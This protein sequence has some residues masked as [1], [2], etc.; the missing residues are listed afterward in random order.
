MKAAALTPLAGLLMGNQSCQQSAPRELRKIVHMGQIQSQPLVIPGG[1][2][3][4]FKS[5]ANEQATGVIYAADGFALRSPNPVAFT[6]S[7]MQGKFTKADMQM[8]AKAGMLETRNNK[9]STEA[10]CMVNLPMAKI[11]G[12]VNA[13]EILGGGGITLGFNPSGA[14]AGISL[15]S[16]NFN[17]DLAQMD[18]SMRATHPITGNVLSNAAVNVTAD[19]TKTRI[20]A[21]INLGLFSIGPSFYYQTPLAQVTKNGLSIAVAQLKEKLKTETWYTRVLANHDTEITVVGGKDVNLV[22]GDQL[23]IYNDVYYWD[24][25]PCASTYRGGTSVNPVAII[26]IEAVGDEVSMGKVIQQTDTNSVVGARAAVYKLYDPNAKAAAAKTPA[27][28]VPS[29][30]TIQ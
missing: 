2:T 30:P 23:A 3:F 15:A 26:Q 27:V 19:Q 1:P 20:S 29:E 28:Q 7:G 10:S 4:D 5:V 6:A 12:S 16:L 11:Q 8:L 25:E 14:Y 9:Y 13:F 21:G 22:V 18:L 24:G 17:V